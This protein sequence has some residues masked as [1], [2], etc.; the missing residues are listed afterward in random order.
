MIV[1]ASIKTPYRTY[2]NLRLAA[3]MSTAHRCYLA[4]AGRPKSEKIMVLQ[5]LTTS[6]SLTARGTKQQSGRPE[7]PQ[8]RRGPVACKARSAPC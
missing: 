4:V 3:L 6:R 5:G 7:H 1:D 2:Q 8:D